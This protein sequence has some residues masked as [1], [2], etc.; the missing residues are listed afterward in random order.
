MSYEPDRQYTSRNVIY[1]ES[2]FDG[3]API[4]WNLEL[5]DPD[6]LQT[7]V[8]ST[9]MLVV[10]GW[11]QYKLVATDNQ[12]G[13]WRYRWYGRNA[14]NESIAQPDDRHWVELTVD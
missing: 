5:I 4:E 11:Y 1:I 13:V 3:S 6:G 7:L 9:S 14:L 8:A 10:D 12:R 2:R